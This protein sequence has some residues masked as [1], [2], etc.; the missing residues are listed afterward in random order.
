M[1]NGSTCCRRPH[2]R[3]QVGL[4]RHEGVPKL[5]AGLERHHDL[6]TEGLWGTQEGKPGGTYSALKPLLLTAA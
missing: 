5:A 1:L 3:G 2:L 4:A 6:G